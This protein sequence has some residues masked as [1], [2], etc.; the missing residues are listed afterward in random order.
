MIERATYRSAAMSL[1]YAG[2]IA[3][4]DRDT[5]A[6]A[7]TQAAHVL[8][9]PA[10]SSHTKT[11]GDIPDLLVAS[12][13]SGRSDPGSGAPRRSTPSPTSAPACNSGTVQGIR[14][15]LKDGFVFLGHRGLG[16]REVRL[17]AS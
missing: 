2:T 9:G 11:S 14:P 7:R 10:A 13:K 1:S 8:C 3:L 6:D 4:T 15:R 12:A 16:W 17:T 5:T